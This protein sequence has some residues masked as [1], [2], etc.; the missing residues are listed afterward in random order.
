MPMNPRLLRPTASG[1]FNPKKIA[2]LELWLDA[3]NSASI[4]LNG[5]NVSQWNDL[6]GN[7]RHATNATAAEQ[8]LYLPTG[9]NSKGAVSFT[10]T[11]THRMHGVFSRTL[12]GMTVFVLFRY[13][14]VGNNSN[15]RF[16]AMIVGGLNDFGGTNHLSPLLRHGGAGQVNVGPYGGGNIAAVAAASYDTPLVYSLV[17]DGSTVSTRINN[18]A[19]SSANRTFNTIYS[20]YALG[21]YRPSPLAGDANMDG[22]LAEIIVY[23]SALSDAAR[24]QV[25][26]YLSTKW[27][28]TIS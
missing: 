1:G 10:R 22:Y 2:G 14:N 16:F 24:V 9:I 21:S 27:G 25:A 26:T 7:G 17:A 18:G 4:T 13:S 11:S 15:N 8:P 12:T 5:S 23:G 28:V 3:N 6:S 20:N 19:A